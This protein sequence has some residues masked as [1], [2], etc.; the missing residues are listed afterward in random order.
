[1]TDPVLLHTFCGQHCWFCDE[2]IFGDGYV[3]ELPDYTGTTC[4]VKCFRQ[5]SKVRFISEYE[6]DNAQYRYVPEGSVGYVVRELDAVVIY[7][8]GECFWFV[9]WPDCVE[10]V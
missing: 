6:E 8:N 2:P 10:A 3:M 7:V 9:G 1:M 5:M 4:H